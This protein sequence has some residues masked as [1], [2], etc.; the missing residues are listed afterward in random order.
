LPMLTVIEMRKRYIVYIR[1]ILSLTIFLVAVY[2]FSLFGGP[3]MVGAVYTALLL[4]SNI[5][6]ML[7]PARMYKGIKLHY[8]VF[9]LDISFLVMALFIFTHID[10]IFI[11]LVFLTVFISALSQSV[12][13]SLI[14]AVVVN[15]L[16]IFIIS[17]Q[18]PAGYNFWDDKALL[19]IPFI[20]II[21][22][23]SSYLAEKAND[24]M[25]DRRNLEKINRV[26]TR[27]VMSKR[28]ENT[29]LII[30]TEALLNGFKFGVLMLDT[31]GFVQI[32]NKA[33]GAML[34]LSP[35]KT[36]G[37]VV[38]DINITAEI[39][40]AIMNLQFK[41][42]ETNEAQVAGNLSATVSLMLNETGETAGILCTFRKGVEDLGQTV[43]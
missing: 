26:L 3:I 38:K 32:M 7:L 31:D 41:G 2:N 35:A 5:L 12:S 13:L 34:G 21:A 40:D 29:G 39:K 1:G 19:N 18:N 36:V 8:L 10:L 42:L 11:V 28:Q 33:A 25:L 24:L 9:L 22:L 23:H 43:K 15:A 37:M 27:K 30:F 17:I 16:Y 4:L 6:F 14:I 20:F